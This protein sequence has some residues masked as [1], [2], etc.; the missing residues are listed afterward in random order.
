ME[1]EKKLKNSKK[2]EVKN[3]TKETESKDEIDQ[4]EE[5]QPNAPKSVYDGP[6]VFS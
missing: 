2:N 1:T 6:S 3:D 5:K 4:K